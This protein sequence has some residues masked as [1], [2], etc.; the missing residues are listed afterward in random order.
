MD[1]LKLRLKTIADRIDAMSMRERG[2]IFFAV[3]VVLY[4]IAYNV[5][6]G[7]LRTD[8][9]RLEQDLKSKRQQ[10]QAADQQVAALFST[11]GKD[12]NA[13]NRAK[14]AALTQ[15]IKELDGQM[16][17]MTAGVVTPKEMAKLIEQM[18]T[19]NKNLELVKLEALPSV[20]IDP[21]AKTAATAPVAGQVTVYRHGMRVEFKG[22]YFDIVEYLKALEGLPWKVFWGEVSLESDKYPVSK[23]S[24]VIYTLSRYPGWIGV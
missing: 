4:L 1:A 11:D 21:E 8:Q 16:D 5:V 2:L 17:R 3:M 7:S 15:Q 20:A 10:I 22:R 18:L 19:R 13:D 6:F 24:L 14:V 23:V 9:V 12:L